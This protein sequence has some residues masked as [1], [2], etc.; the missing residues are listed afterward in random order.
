MA[1]QVFQGLDYLFV[2][3][4]FEGVAEVFAVDLALPRKEYNPA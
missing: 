2:G 4:V 1:Y 3:A